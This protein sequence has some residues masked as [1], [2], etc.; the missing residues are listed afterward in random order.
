M[1]FGWLCCCS[2]FISLLSAR[3]WLLLMC[4][5]PNWNEINLLRGT[6]EGEKK[7][8]RLFSNF[9]IE[10]V[11]WVRWFRNSVGKR[12]LRCYLRRN[13][14]TKWRAHDEHSWLLSVF[15]RRAFHTPKEKKITL[16]IQSKRKW[17]PYRNV[18]GLMNGFLFIFIFFCFFFFLAWITDMWFIIIWCL[19]LLFI[20]A[21]K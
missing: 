11:V 13:S 15:V 18:D 10:F 17:K 3:V 7:T 8:R 20:S 16:L 12:L 14:L 4:V 21:K 9:L 1:G 5:K 6:E 19:G 2:I